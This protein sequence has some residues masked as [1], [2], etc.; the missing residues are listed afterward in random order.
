[1]CGRYTLRTPTSELIEIFELVRNF[2]LTPRYNIAPTQSVPAVRESPGPESP[3]AGPAGERRR[4][5]APHVWGLIPPWSDDPRIGGRMINARSETAATKA[6][7]RDAFRRRRCLIPA[8]GF[9]EWKKDGKTKQPC[10]ITLHDERPFA[11]AGLW[12]R[13]ERPDC[14]P[15]DSCTIL[16][17]QANDL[18]R[19]L[20]DRMPL[21]LHREDYDRWLDAN[22]RPEELEPLLRPFPSAEMELREVSTHV[23]NARNEGPDCVRPPVAEKHLC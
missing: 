22:A 17:T 21:I 14:P 13:W 20:H 23:N 11:F 19:P 9:Y 4:E 16:T 7:F 5:F 18:L 1:M 2:E 3:G 10:L 8:D 12:E 15:I 6:A